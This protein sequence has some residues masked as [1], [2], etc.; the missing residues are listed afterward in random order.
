MA[1]QLSWWI[2]AVLLVC[3]VVGFA[4]LPP[5][6][7]PFFARRFQ[8]LGPTPYRLRVQ[9]LADDWRSTALEL[10]LLQYREQLRPELERR[11]AHDVPGP[12]L[13]F[14][15]P[16]APDSVRHPF[17][18]YLDAEWRR[19]GLGVS[20]VSVGIVIAPASQPDPGHPREET[21]TTA[22]LLPDST[23][24]ST[25]IVFQEYA[26]IARQRPGLGLCAYYAA[27]G[28]PG[29][30]IGR[31][32]AARDYD[33][34]ILPLWSRARTPGSGQRLLE[35]DQPWFWWQVYRHQPAGVACL[36]GR[37]E[38][39]RSAVMGGP[40][41]GHDPS[42]LVLIDRRWWRRPPALAGGERYLADVVRSV[43]HERFLRFWNSE[44]P[45]DSALAEAL[46]M[47]VGDWTRRWQADFV[48]QIQLGP[49]PAA[50]SALLGLLLAAAAMGIVLRTVPRR[51]VR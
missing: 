10:R 7:T 17:G 35:R 37:R 27:F 32:L 51:E 24:R 15:W 26:R 47:P 11:T 41:P 6:A 29:R 49:A 5:R 45:A 2:G 50:G 3:A 20:K 43:G 28:N 30:E 16:D 25:C 48:P 9:A 14:D 21:V 4:Y 13:L 31:W 44:L 33:L 18:T 8:V 38:G 46:R 12:A 1:R 42:H 19:L 40:Q 22:Y 23:D 34:A 39:C 36:A